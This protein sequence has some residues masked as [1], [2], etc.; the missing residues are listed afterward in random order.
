MGEERH[1]QAGTQ[2][3]DNGNPQ[4]GRWDVAIRVA[5]VPKVELKTPIPRTSITQKEVAVE[6]PV[7]RVVQDLN[8]CC[9]GNTD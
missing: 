7:G 3:L 8:R 6:Y 4:L 5:G 1:K 9:G 2:I